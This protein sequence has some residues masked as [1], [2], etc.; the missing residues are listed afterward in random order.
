MRFERLFNLLL[1][2]PLELRRNADGTGIGPEH[3][4]FIDG[5][6]RYYDARLKGTSGMEAREY[7][8]KDF[9]WHGEIE[10]AINDDRKRMGL[11]PIWTFDAS[12]N[13]ATVNIQG[14]LAIHASLF[15][16]DCMGMCSYDH[17]QAALQ[18]I[19]LMHPKLSACILYVNSPGGQVT[20][21]LETAELVAQL[22]EKVPV[23]AYTD[24]LCCSAALKLAAPAHELHA[25]PTAVVGSIGT[26][27]AYLDD[28]EYLKE[29]GL[30]W[31]V[32]ASGDLKGT[33][34]GPL[35]DAQRAHLQ[36]QIDFSGNRFKAWM[37]EHR[38]GLTEADMRGQWWD[39]QSAPAALLDSTELLTIDY[40]RAYATTLR[41]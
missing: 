12:T 36:Q 23:L 21:S 30:K 34:C 9:R 35:S 1:R 11:A 13:T 32:I 2:Q 17:I 31:E 26:I 33:F 39:A 37:T 24:D 19:P 4:T 8:P 27:I 7:A 6:V 28:T 20:G 40:A 29:L 15:E 3:R 16:M 5:L 18:E 41:R 25:S 10:G 22:A 14:P 38:P